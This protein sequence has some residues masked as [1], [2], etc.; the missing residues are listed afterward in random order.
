M[1]KIKCGPCNKTIQGYDKTHAE[2]LMQRH[3]DSGKHKRK[4]QEDKGNGKKN[5]L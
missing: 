4:E 3:K 2:Y 5:N 1:H